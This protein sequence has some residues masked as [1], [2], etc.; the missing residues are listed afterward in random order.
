MLQKQVKKIISKKLRE[1]ESGDERQA[2]SKRTMFASDNVDSYQRP[3]TSDIVL[4][5]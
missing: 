1:E 2:K 4:L 3:A 5:S